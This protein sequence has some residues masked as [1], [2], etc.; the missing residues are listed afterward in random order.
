MRGN[1]NFGR[2]ANAATGNQSYGWFSSGQQ[3]GNYPSRVERIDFSNDLSLAS[4]R[5]PLTNS[6][7]FGTATTNARSS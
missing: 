7:F 5:G 4:I 3:G 6:S 2:N 1:F